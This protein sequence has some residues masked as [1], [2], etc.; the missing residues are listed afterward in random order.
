MDIWKGIPGYE[1]LYQISNAGSVKRLGNT[2][3]CVKERIL[4]ASH[5]GNGYLSVSLCRSGKPKKIG[6]HRLVAWA[7]IGQQGKS[8]V[9]HKNGIKSD[10]WIENIE[11]TTPGENAQHAYD[12]GLQP[13]RKGEGNGHS[14]LTA[15]EVIFIRQL[16]ESGM[17]RKNIC[18]VVGYSK[19]TIRDIVTGN[20]WESA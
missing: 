2:P 11:Y 8:W 4:K 12:I 9:N 17:A 16:A 5:D 20:S 10:N 1:D 3:K 14:K 13:S 6:V 15:K 19:T 7:F 18:K